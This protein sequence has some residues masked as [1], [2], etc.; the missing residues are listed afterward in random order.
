MISFIIKRIKSVSVASKGILYMLKYEPNAW[1]HTL[2]TVLVFGSGIYYGLTRFEW[3]WI[4]LAIV[5]VWTAEALNTALEFLADVASP[6]SHALVEKA[7]DVAAGG[8]L[9]TSLGS[10]IIAILIFGPYMVNGLN[11]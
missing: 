1:V 4:V 9:I 2:A 7:K 10:I 3:C 11:R 6:D 8:V 5:S